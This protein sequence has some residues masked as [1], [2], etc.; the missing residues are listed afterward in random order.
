MSII[1]YFNFCQ[2]LRY[3][4]N[5]SNFS[6][7]G[8]ALPPQ[9]T[10][11]CLAWEIA[12]VYLLP[13]TPEK[14]QKFVHIEVLGKNC[15]NTWLT[16]KEPFSNPI[17]N[18]GSIGHPGT[19]YSRFSGRQ[20]RPPKSGSFH[21]H[22]MIRQLITT[23]PRNKTIGEVWSIDLWFYLNPIS[24]VQYFNDLILNSTKPHCKQKK[25]SFWH[26]YWALFVSE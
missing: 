9:S 22:S 18:S 26:V 3:E 7:V 2:G 23:F 6:G 24:M 11:L 16:S 13:P 25:N 12:Y 21:Y 17:G 1:K 15:S 14:F 4:R 20:M 19:V 8:G 10:S 5:F